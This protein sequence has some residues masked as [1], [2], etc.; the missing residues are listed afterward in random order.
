MATAPV[1]KTMNRDDLPAPEG[2]AFVTEP[3]RLAEVLEDGPGVLPGR[4]TSA[5]MRAR[6]E[7]RPNGQ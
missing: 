2:R 3:N 5:I 1:I 7:K 4:R 6:A